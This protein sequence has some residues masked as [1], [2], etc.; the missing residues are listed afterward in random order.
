MKKIFFELTSNSKK[1]EKKKI[2]K[3]EVQEDEIAATT[4]TTKNFRVKELLKD[5]ELKY[6]ESQFKQETSIKQLCTSGGYVISSFLDSV[7]DESGD[8]DTFWLENSDKSQSYSKTPDMKDYFEK[9]SIAANVRSGDQRMLRK[10]FWFREKESYD[11]KTRFLCKSLL[12]FR[13]SLHFSQMFAYLSKKLEMPYGSNVVSVAWSTSGGFLACGC[14]TG[15][16]KVLKIE[17]V[18]QEQENGKPKGYLAAPTNISKNQTLE[19]HTASISAIAWNQKQNKLTTTDVKG[20]TIVWKF[21]RNSWCEE[22]VHNREG[23][24]VT[25]LSWSNCGKK[26]C[27]IYRDGG[28]MVG[29]VEGSRI[30]GSDSIVE[31]STLTGVSWS[32][33]GSQ[34]LFAVSNGEI[35]VYSQDG[36]LEKTLVLK[37]LSHRKRDILEEQETEPDELNSIVCIRWHKTSTSCFNWTVPTLAVIWK[38]NCMYLLRN[39]GDEQPVVTKTQMAASCGAWSSNGD[40]IAVGGSPL[41]AN[42]KNQDVGQ[43][44]TN[45]FDQVN[46]FSPFGTFLQTIKFPGTSCL[47]LGWDSLSLRLAVGVGENV[48]FA[49]VR[50][51]YKFSLFGSNTLVYAFSRCDGAAQIGFWDGQSV[52]VQE[53]PGKV[54]DIKGNDVHCA[55]LSLTTTGCYNATILNSFGDPVD[56]ITI[57]T[58]D[59]FMINLTGSVLIAV[60]YNAITIWRFD[61]I[62]RD[63]AV[64]CTNGVDLVARRRLRSFHIDESPSIIGESTDE[65]KL[66]ESTLDPASCSDAVGQMLIV[67]RESG[68][69]QIYSLPHGALMNTIDT[70]YEMNFRPSRIWLNMDGSQVAMID[71]LGHLSVC[72]LGSASIKT[73]LARKLDRKDVWNII[74]AADNPNLIC[75]MEKTKMYVIRN[76][77]AEDPVLT[78]AYVASFKDLKVTSVLMDELMFKPEEPSPD[79]FITLETKALR[80]T[81]RLLES[82]T[83]LKDVADSIQK[84]SH[85]NLWK[86][87]GNEALKQINL[88]VAE[89]SFAKSCDYAGIS[90]VKRLGSISNMLLQRAEVAA[91][92]NEHEKASEYYIQADRKDIACNMWKMLNDW[93]NVDMALILSKQRSSD[94]NARELSVAKGDNYFETHEWSKALS[95]YEAAEETSKMFAC[96]LFLEDYSRLEK[97]IEGLHE[98]DLLLLKL[99][100]LFQSRGLCKEA[101]NAYLKYDYE[102]PEKAIEVAISLTQWNLALQVAQNYSLDMVEPLLLRYVV[103]LLNSGK[104]MTAVQ[105]MTKSR[106]PYGAGKLLVITALRELK[107]QQKDLI[108]IKKLFVYAAMLFEYQGVTFIK[109]G[110]ENNCI[111]R[112]NQY[113][114]DE[115]SMDIFFENSIPEQH[116]P[117]PQIYKWMRD[118]PWRGAEAVH[119]LILTQ[120]LIYKGIYEPATRTALYLRSYC[121]ILGDELVHAMIALAS[122]N[123]C[124]FGVCSRAFMRLETIDEEY[125]EVASELFSK[126]SPADNCVQTVKCHKCQLDIPDYS[127]LCPEC[128]TSFEICAFT[129][130]PLCDDTANVW[131]CQVCKHSSDLKEIKSRHSCPFCHSERL[132]SLENL[133]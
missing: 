69:L 46:V 28:V 6:L 126:Y 30:W 108:Q 132:S 102:H 38:Y 100:E 75:V 44:K 3:K 74:W 91:Y 109:H 63:D 86:L 49:N 45:G 124:N 66:K 114:N 105:L 107:E 43:L 110:S 11:V 54:V 111:G 18:E 128:G 119:Y 80:E 115:D 39:V 5:S 67:C 88:E 120:S 94:T 31:D 133:H 90:M 13:K 16:I 27:I 10:L 24:A 40:F 76:G 52:H 34:V 92:F 25:D 47:S 79:L 36:T 122:I 89:S 32:P 29:S 57:V 64:S 42:S 56:S 50:P 53:I 72:S 98:G 84:N 117:T 22:M 26:V 21:C 130:R 17:V 93:K 85:R 14:D 116:R 81:R 19:G 104:I 9:K 103:H 60:A 61:Y 37:E 55:I 83:A 4:V 129:G 121:D 99:A 20:L 8:G 125:S 35:L 71:K 68:K 96:F 48:Y 33:S 95:C 118:T 2:V 7:V 59:P 123:S 106:K 58:I 70:A 23:F 41:T 65:A 78:S 62:S 131:T 1:K 82:G 51:C 127:T 73:A 101:I 97:F 15:L 12:Q 87:L 112:S 113:Y 77:E